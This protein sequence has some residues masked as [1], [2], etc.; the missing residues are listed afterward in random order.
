MDFN[1]NQPC[2]A[3]KRQP[4]DPHHIRSRGAGGGD[5]EFNVLAVCRC[6][7]AYIHACG[8]KEFSDEWYPI[9]AWLRCHGWNFDNRNHLVRV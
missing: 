7:H 5:E 2:I 4:V 3:C 8:M 9:E 6:C 1:H